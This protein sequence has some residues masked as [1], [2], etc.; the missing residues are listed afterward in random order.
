MEEAETV[1][2]PEAKITEDDEQ[3]STSTAAQ[4]TH[5]AA[6][7]VHEDE[8]L[9]NM[10]TAEE[11]LMRKNIVLLN[12]EKQMFLDLVHADGLIVC[13]KYVAAETMKLKF[14]KISISVEV[15]IMIACY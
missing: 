4:E 6:A 7:A 8:D 14:I 10:V 9:A 11:Y 13:A 3:P 12:Y 15:F 1:H 5:V 2:L